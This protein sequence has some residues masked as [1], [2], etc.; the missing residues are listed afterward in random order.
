MSA[1]SWNMRATEALKSLDDLGLIG[2]SEHAAIAG[3]QH[4]LQTK[5]AHNAS[6]SD[7][8]RVEIAHK[9]VSMVYTPHLVHIPTSKA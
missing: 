5:I 3:G 6:I 2:Q 9:K 1:T 4:A 7:L 8:Q